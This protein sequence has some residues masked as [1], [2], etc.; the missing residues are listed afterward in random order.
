MERNDQ[1]MQGGDNADPK[2]VQSRIVSA[3]S[4]GFVL[5]PED[6]D[7]DGMPNIDKYFTTNIIRASQSMA[8]IA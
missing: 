7:S 5:E 6:T 8:P 1:A 4:Q 3:T 2:Y